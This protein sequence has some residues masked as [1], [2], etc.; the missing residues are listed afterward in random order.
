MQAVHLA[1]ITND[2]FA[3]L[4]VFVCEDTKDQTVQLN[5]ETKGGVCV[6]DQENAFHYWN[7]FYVQKC[8]K[9]K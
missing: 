4:P 5:T 2:C 3:S 9:S 7:D 8:S 6:Y 1:P